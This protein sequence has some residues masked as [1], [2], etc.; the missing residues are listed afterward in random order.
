[1]K[2]YT[3][4]IRLTDNNEEHL[5]FLLLAGEGRAAEGGKLEGECVFMPIP[6]N[7]EVMIGGPF[8]ILTEHQKAGDHQY[9]F[10]VSGDRASFFVSGP[11]ERMFLLTLGPDGKGEWGTCKDDREMRKLGFCYA[12]N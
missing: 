2:N 7:P 3:G 10:N 4:P 12:S 8:R 6:Q 11:L 1:M 9:E 5:G